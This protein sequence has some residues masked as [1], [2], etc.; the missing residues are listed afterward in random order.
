MTVTSAVAALPVRRESPSFGL[1][2][3]GA[4]RTL[5]LAGS[6]LIALNAP[7]AGFAQTAAPQPVP[8]QAAPAAAPPSAPVF[9][10]EELDQI[11][12]PIAL[13]PDDLLMQVLMASSYPLEIVQAQRWVADPK[14]AA[15]KGDQLSDALE[16]QR[17]D[18]S[19]KSLVPFPQIL[20]MMSDQ[21]DW[22]Q[23][24]GD[25]V[26]AQQKDVLDA[27]QRLRQRAQANG[28]LKSNEQQTVSVQAA[29]T[30]PADQSGSGQAVQTEQTAGGGQQTIVI[31][32]ANPQTVYVPAYNPN[33]VYG[34]WPYPSYPPPYYPPPPAYY[35]GYYAG[36]ALA[37]GLT[38]AAGVAVTGALWGWGSA[39][40]G[41]GSININNNV[42]NNINRGNINA[43][44]ASNFSGNSWRHD[45]S[46]RGGV[47]Y[48][49]SATR[50]QFR[51]A[52]AGGAASRQNFR[53]FDNS[54]RTGAQGANR[55]GTQAG[56]RTGAQ[57]GNR[58]G[59]QAG[60]RTGGQAANRAGAQAGNRAGGQAANRAGAQAGNRAGTG[61]VGQGG[62]A[63]NARS[64]GQARAS[65]GAFGGM[66]SGA[67]TRAQSARGNA[68]RGAMQ[69][70]AA[71]AGG[72]GRGGGG[73]G[74]RR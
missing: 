9:K 32:P 57:A 64:A 14:N 2:R 56:N 12:A 53:G 68:S 51:N 7:E 52:S 74:R 58:V 24:L 42:Y 61:G 10:M 71:S 73:G 66:G 38:F 67:Q 69:P 30:Q 40:W 15:L 39:N 35:P 44:R 11:V 45:S 34:T 21:L 17:W 27:I 37:T 25:A 23:R 6:L 29:A 55:L 22:T 28:S 54:A 3:I 1:R 31:Q 50:Q 65:P 20:Q 33:D 16:D 26:L 43:G 63:A 59:A 48:R 72:G 36:A 70:R 4:N 19:V 46:H 8:A 13:Y 60:N 41:G 49:D 5:A 62:A 47:A 18:P